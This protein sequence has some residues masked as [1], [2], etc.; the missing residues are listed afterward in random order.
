MLYKG[1]IVDRSVS[2]V[3]QLIDVIKT[4]EKYAEEQLGSE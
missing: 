2:E 4:K 3:I 1:L